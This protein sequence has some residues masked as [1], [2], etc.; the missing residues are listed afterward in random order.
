MHHT[1]FKLPSVKLGKHQ[2]LSGNVVYYVRV[3]APF[4]S[5]EVCA[6]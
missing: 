3:P 1:V 6:S 5:P 2:L 4:G